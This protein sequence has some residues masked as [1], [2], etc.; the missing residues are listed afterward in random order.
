[1][2]RRVVA[3]LA[4]DV[5]GF[6]RLMG[7]DEDATLKTLHNHFALINQLIDERHGRNFSGAGDSILAEFPSPVQAVQ[8]AI[9]IQQGIRERNAALPDARRM[10]MRIG[11]NIGEVVVENDNLLGSS[12]NL[13]ARI[14]GLA[15][16][17]GVVISELTYR[18]VK[19]EVK[20]E[21]EDMGAHRLKGFPEPVRTFRI[22]IF[23]KLSAA[24]MGAPRELESPPQ[25]NEPAASR[26]DHRNDS[27][28]PIIVVLPFVNLSGDPQQ[29]YFC[30]G[31][32]NDITTELSRF[33]SLAVVSSMTAYSYKSRPTRLREASH[34]LDVRYLLEG[35]VQKT[36]DRIRINIQ[37]IE[38][39]DDQ[40]IWAERFDRAVSDLFS[41]QDEIIERV[42]ASLAL[43]MEAVERGRAMHKPTDNLN[44]YDAFLRGAYLWLLHSNTDES[45]ETLRESRGW[46]EKATALDPSYGR[47]WAWLSLTYVQEWLQSW[48]GQAA[49]DKAGKLAKKALIVDADDYNVH[50]N[51]AY[52]HLN[53]RQ[54]DLALSEY[55]VA[56]SLNRNDANLLAE[57][58]EALV[59]VGRHRAGLDLIRQ[60]S[61]MNPHS[62]EWYRADIAWVNYLLGE[63]ETGISEIA[64][65][66]NPNPGALLVLTACHGR[67][68]ARQKTE[69]RPDLA[70]QHEKLAH[71]ALDE[72]KSMRTGWTIAKE[73]KKSPFKNESDLGHWLDGL[74]L[75]GLPE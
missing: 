24:E 8:C 70:V 61:R 18:R 30:H 32:T 23:D 9:E 15:D 14:E 75:A 28:K 1:M 4:A 66:A 67:M 52:Y 65:M 25:L 21:F 59:Y 43:K 11:I 46:L 74:R 16:P 20:A 22:G 2:E 39:P 48:D 73:R 55:D 37:L 26:T 36:A 6:S 38:A 10:L 72:F 31:L 69:G 47:A 34:D 62:S 12:I 50:W 13:A 35:S 44:A 60:A 45:Q 57:Y 68:V 19:D 17:G 56:V 64:R 41:L 27:R 40:H 58:G 3:I 29:E 42:V 53:A 71:A 54:F 51:L 33:S 63:Y 7:R 5:V 49:L